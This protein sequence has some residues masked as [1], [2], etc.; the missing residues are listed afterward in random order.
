MDYDTLETLRLKHPAWNLL[1]A[2]LAPL[3]ASFLHKHFLLP[4][5]RSW[6]QSE[7]AEKL[8]D[9]LYR[10][11][12]SAGSESFPRSALAYL[13]DWAQDDKAWLR[14]YYPAGSDEP[15]FDLTPAS[16]KAIGW[17]T[18]LTQRAFVGTESRLLMVFELLKQLVEGSQ[19][20]P[21]ARLAEL[22]S[23]REEINEEMKRVRAGHLDVLDQTAQRDRF[24]QLV[25]T[26]RELLGDFREVEQNFRQ[27][28]R[29]LRER[30][31]LWDGSKG[32]LL[33]EILGERDAITDSDQGRS[34]QAFWDFLMS[35]SKQEEFSS[36]LEQAL[37]LPA[38]AQTHPDRRIRR[39]HYDW[40]N[41]G[42]H[43]QRTVSTLSQQLR[44]LLDDRTWLENRRI[45]EILHKLEGHA[46]ALRD[47]M[48]AGE[49]F[50]IDDLSASLELPMERPLF[51]P[52]LKS[53]L[54][55]EALE[56]GQE[57][58]DTA[59][60]FSQFHID[61]AELAARVRQ[62]L[63]ARHQVSLAEVVAEHPLQQGLA[64]LVAYLTLASDSPQ[65]V[66][67][68]ENR[69]KITW[70]SPGGTDKTATLPRVLFVR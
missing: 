37:Q 34:F 62:S 60:L 58:L 8:E 39:I 50:S 6:P 51:N 2:D 9:E 48:P 26:A 66:F 30:I 43:T 65:S 3:V 12:Q 41:A 25:Q 5:Q 47:Q 28:D 20:D 68:E 27:L 24:Q 56:I 61:K 69:Q 63:G 4:N 44:R 23:R 22:R 40:L 45:M 21:E 18:G 33:D 11:R 14:K 10:L 31:A 7:L 46:V 19:T 32:R 17:L 54:T 55:S 49:I 53:I 15:H 67:D 36:L 16:E 29:N 57:E 35:Q 52:P 70:S 13:D 59:A 1:R 42:E 64:E 38:V